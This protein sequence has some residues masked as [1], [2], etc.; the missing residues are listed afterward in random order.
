MNA[1]SITMINKQNS[2]SFF[3]LNY[4]DIIRYRKNYDFTACLEHFIKHFEIL[5]KTDGT[6]YSISEILG[7][8]HILLLKDDNNKASLVKIHDLFVSFIQKR[9]SDDKT[10]NYRPFTTLYQTTDKSYTYDRIL[11]ENNQPISMVNW[12]LGKFKWIDY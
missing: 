8:D 11:D 6:F 1:H 9:L 2:F 7:N 4:L 12:K 10:E 3:T 5:K